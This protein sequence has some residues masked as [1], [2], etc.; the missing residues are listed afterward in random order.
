MSES[1]GL[2]SPLQCPMIAEAW[3]SRW[4]SD[5]LGSPVKM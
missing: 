2:G 1:G 3:L 4:D 5:I